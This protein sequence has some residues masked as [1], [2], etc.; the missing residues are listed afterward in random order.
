M[1]R[2]KVEGSAIEVYEFLRDF[3]Q[4]PQYQVKNRSSEY[5]DDVLP[6]DEVIS[7]CHFEFTPVFEKKEIILTLDI[8]NYKLV[9]HITDFELCAISKEISYVKGSV[10]NLTVKKTQVETKV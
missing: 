5:Q 10:E 9:L 2:L 8:P 1:L 4:Q 6:N 7:Y 3:E